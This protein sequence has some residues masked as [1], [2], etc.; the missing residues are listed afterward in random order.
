MQQDFLQNL[1]HRLN[2]IDIIG[3][4]LSLTKKGSA[5]LALCPFHND[6]KPSMN[7]SES[8]Q[9]YKCFACGAG[10]DVFKFVMEYEHKG[11]KEVVS[12]LAESVGLEVPGQFNNPQNQQIKQFEKELI[13]N[14][15]AMQVF[16]LF[17][18]KH[19]KATLARDYVRKRKIPKAA[20]VNYKIGSSPDEWDFISRYASGEQLQDAAEKAG[21][22]LRKKSGYGQFD[23]FRNRLLFPII[24]ERQRVL[25]FGGRS[26]D[27]Q[28][29]KYINTKD[30]ALFKKSD[31]LY[32]MDKLSPL[33]NK[34][35]AIYICEG[36]L[37]VIACQLAGL[38]ALAPLGTAFTESQAIKLK[39]YHKKLIFLFDGDTAGIRAAKKSV[40]VAI[41]HQ[42]YS[43]VVILENGLDP[44]D[45]FQNNPAEKALQ[46]IS[47][48]AID[49]LKFFISQESKGRENDP[50]IKREI[51][52]QLA[53]VLE[54]VEDPVYKDSYKKQVSK[55]LEIDSQLI[56]S[57]RK[58][59]YKKDFPAQK[60]PEQK[61]NNNPFELL[62]KRLALLCCQSPSSIKKIV[63]IL[64]VD[65]VGDDFSRY[66]LTVILKNR[67]KEKASLVD[68]LGWIPDERVEN[69]IRSQVMKNE[70]F[71]KNPTEQI[72]ECLLKLKIRQLD[73]ESQNL[74]MR[75]QEAQ[76]QN[77]D[78]EIVNIMEEK[79][80]IAQE[81]EHLKN[82]YA[83]G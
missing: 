40:L 47:A 9:I 19:K 29:P 6:S 60:N 3:Q 4:R 49:G 55:L 83:D 64:D 45:L 53:S 67:D 18:R 76:L 37:D 24:D 13:I 38:A 43:E 56:Q 50:Q 12:E 62:E 71:H 54:Q 68:V 28:E 48:S 41:R 5:Y 58:A 2:I 44:F 80:R 79:Q 15:K 26:I 72:D 65:R 70:E 33:L 66:V 14:E 27:G 22:V 81:R 10:G 73:F 69:Y 59:F 74:E 46:I 63:Q 78:Q 42:L 34:S 20:L 52:D 8:K 25:G 75:L 35:E 39:R 82:F 32:G 61:Q 57:S 1:R 31:C 23:F 7:I 16:H 77:M 21:L 30:T 51:I 17:L 11:F 36:Y